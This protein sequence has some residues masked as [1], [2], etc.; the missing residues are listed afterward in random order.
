MGVGVAMLSALSLPPPGVAVV[1][2]PP[3]E[4]TT[5]PP[6]EKVPTP[7]PGGAAI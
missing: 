3:A 1:P 2:K 4:S 7:L 6:A 5:S